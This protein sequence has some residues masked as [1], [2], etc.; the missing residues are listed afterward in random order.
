MG[1]GRAVYFQS[2]EGMVRKARSQE[3]HVFSRWHALHVDHTKTRD[4]R[5]KLVFAEKQVA[6]PVPR[7]NDADNIWGPAWHAWRDG[8][9]HWLEYA[10]GD[11]AGTDRRF[12]IGADE[13]ERLRSDLDQ[14]EPIGE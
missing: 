13:F 12:A 9:V 1:G 7:R 3:Y 11:H 6:C 8:N 5:I 4:S 14:F 2:T 10:T